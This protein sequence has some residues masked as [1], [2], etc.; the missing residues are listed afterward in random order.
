VGVVPKASARK[1]RLV[2]NTRCVNGH[3]I[4]KV[5]KFEDMC[6]LAN[7][8]EKGHHSVSYDFTPNYYQVGLHA[9]INRI[10]ALSAMVC[11]W[12]CVHNCLPIGLSTIVS[13]FSKAMR[14]WALFWEE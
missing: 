7:L 5:F 9:S 4:N 13:V 6:D 3:H 2:M 1:L 12:Y 10:R 11:S 14:V 8:N